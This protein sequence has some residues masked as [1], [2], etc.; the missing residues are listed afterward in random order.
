[1]ADEFRVVNVDRRQFFSGEALNISSNFEAMLEPPLSSLVVWVQTKFGHSDTAQFRGAWANDRVVIAGEDGDNSSIYNA[2]DGF[3]DEVFEDVSVPLIE[4][5]ID[6]E[7]YRSI[8]HWERGW[9]DDNGKFVFDANERKRLAAEHENREFPFANWE[10]RL[11]GI[12]P[13]DVK[14]AHRKRRRNC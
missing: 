10:E 6:Y 3:E 5:W 8:E 7:V 14:S 2:C 4:E 12:W 13:T 11:T 9:V 1:M